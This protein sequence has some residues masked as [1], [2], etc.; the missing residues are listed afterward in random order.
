[1]LERLLLESRLADVLPK[2]WKARIYHVS[3]PPTASSPILATL[4]SQKDQTTFRESHFLAVASSP[5]G[6]A[7]CSAVFIYAIEVLIFATATLNTVFV[8]KADSS[9]FLPKLNTSKT[10]GSI[11]QSIT[12]VFLDYLLAPCLEKSKVVLSLFARSQHQYLFAGSIE[13]PEKHVLDDRQLIKWWCKILDHVWRPYDHSITPSSKRHS[14]TAY[15]VVPG[16]DKAETRIFFPASTGLDPPA[17]P[18][19]LN[20]YP[21]GFITGDR[22]IPPRC[23]I[24]RLPDDPKSRFLDD[25]DGDY[26]GPEGQWRS[27]KSLSQFWEMMAYRQECHAGRLVGFIWITFQTESL[28]PTTEILHATN[29]ST[30]TPDQSPHSVLP[31]PLHY[32]SEVSHPQ[33]GTIIPEV[34]PESAQPPHPRLSSSPLRHQHTELPF[35]AHGSTDPTTPSINNTT[36]KGEVILTPEN[37]DALM[38]FLLHLDFTGMD[39]AAES[40]RKWT[41]KVIELAPIT[42]FGQTIVGRQIAVGN[43]P[44]LATVPAQEANLLTG[45]RKKRKVDPDPSTTAPPGRQQPNILSSG[46]IRKKPK[47]EMNS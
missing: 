5:E 36:P 3:T 15:L 40:T 6:A 37:Y 9:G 39:T 16:C 33:N 43:S 29:K 32:T 22:N 17:H 10:S 35:Q 2:D 45:I 27:V 20:S 11:V 24:P 34:Q 7:G 31:T 19:W 23:A 46:L 26:V 21:E 18:K 14:V 42:A 28:S 13:N 12:Q 4:P 38:N 8:S 47:K 41:E 44:Q 25:L 30:S 1:M